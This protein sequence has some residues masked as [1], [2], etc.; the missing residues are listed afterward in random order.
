MGWIQPSG[1]V[2]CQPHVL[3]ASCM[4]PRAHS[5]HG[6]Q[7]QHW[8]QTVCSVQTEPGATSTAQ[9][10]GPNRAHRATQGHYPS[11]TAGLV[12][13]PCLGHLVSA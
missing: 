4:D 1:S 8:A 7:S 5:V 10:V 3:C 12:G 6:M 9:G 13:H 11:F 2:P